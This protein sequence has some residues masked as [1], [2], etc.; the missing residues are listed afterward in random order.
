MLQEY[1]DG[2]RNAAI[3]Q[4]SAP[5]ANPYQG[6]YPRVLFVCSAG[7]LRSATGATVGSQLGLNTRNCGSESYALIPLSANL[8][9]WAQKIYFV[10]EYNLVSANIT[11]EGEEAI[12]DMLEAKSVTMNIE[13]SYDYMDPRLVA[14]FTK[15]LS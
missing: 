12:L 14:I 9:A 2:T 15:L 1:T 8:I 4:L 3:F 7:L 5:Y 6:N 13:D 11:F 10:N